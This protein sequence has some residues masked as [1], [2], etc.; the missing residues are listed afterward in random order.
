MVHDASQQQGGPLPVIAFEIWY[1]AGKQF[2][3]QLRTP[4]GQTLDIPASTSEQ[5]CKP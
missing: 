3:Y 2:S 1:D 5:C 4:T